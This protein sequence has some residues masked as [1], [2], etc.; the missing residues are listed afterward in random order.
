MIGGQVCI[1]FQIDGESGRG[2]NLE[3]CY[4]ADRPATLK[5]NLVRLCVDGNR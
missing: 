2:W 4:D 1:Q 3:I 5:G